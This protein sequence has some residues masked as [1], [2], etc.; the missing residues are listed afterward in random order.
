MA[1]VLSVKNTLKSEPSDSLI[2]KYNVLEKNV[3]LVSSNL[4]PVDNFFSNFARSY[5]VNQNEIKKIGFTD[6]VF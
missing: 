3:C 1:T 2:I 5:H 4:N 6:L